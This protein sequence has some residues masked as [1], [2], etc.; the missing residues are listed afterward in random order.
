MTCDIRDFTTLLCIIL[1]LVSSEWLESS[2]DHDAFH[3]N[4]EEG[5]VN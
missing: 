5:F 2:M 4:T 1:R 3:L